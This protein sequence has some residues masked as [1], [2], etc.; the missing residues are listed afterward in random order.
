VSLDGPSL[1]YHRRVRTLWLCVLL[2]ACTGDANDTGETGDTGTSD[3]PTGG[4]AGLGAPC[5]PAFLEGPNVN[6]DAACASGICVYTDA[7]TAP[8]GACASDA[9]CNA[10]DPTVQ[11]FVC[12][13]VCELNESYKQEVTM[14]SQTCDI[15]ED[16]GDVD[17][18]SS[19]AGGFICAAP[20]DNCCQR[21]CL[22]L[23]HVSFGHLDSVAFE[24]E[25]STAC[26][27]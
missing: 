11:R 3:T 7:V 9:E 23:D 15:D 2:C 17:G 16:C 18:A 4:G 26:P 1:L 22:C 25:M 24:C 19:C 12:N 13:N 6:A 20:G 5:E 8:Q 27:L 14:C 21:L 10:A